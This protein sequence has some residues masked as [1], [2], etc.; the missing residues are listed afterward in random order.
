MRMLVTTVLIALVLGIA[1]AAWALWPRERAAADSKNALQAGDPAPDFR[2]AD[3]E[4]K[5][6]RLSDYRGHWLVLYFYPK[7]DTP[8]CTTEACHF[9]DDIAALQALGARVVGVSLDDAASHR[10]FSAKYHL[11]FTLLSDP[12]GKTVAAYGSLFKLGPLA[13]A[14]RHTFIIDPEGRIAK[15]YRDVAPKQ[16]AVEIIAEL[17]RLQAAEGGGGGA[18]E[19][20]PPSPG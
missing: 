15:V 1:V 10:A 4:G 6:H 18:G 5:V 13:M 11:P 16:H 19:T 9:R 8:G 20:A 3:A 14:R 2:L 12:D 17:K 7:D